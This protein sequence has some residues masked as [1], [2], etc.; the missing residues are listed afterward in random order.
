M[1]QWEVNF[2]TSELAK[3]R[4]SHDSL[5]S[6]SN[7]SKQE[8]EAKISPLR[9]ELE[10]MDKPYHQAKQDYQASKSQA[11]KTHT[12]N[13][14]KVESRVQSFIDQGFPEN[15]PHISQARREMVDLSNNHQNHL[16]NLD[17]TFK[18]LETSHLQRTAPLRSR[19][20][21]IQTQHESQISE[22]DKRL[23]NVSGVMNDYRNRLQQVGI[24]ASNWESRYRTAKNIY[25]YESPNP[26]G[27]ENNYA[28][29]ARAKDPRPLP[30]EC[31]RCGISMK[32]G[33]FRQSDKI[34]GKVCIDCRD[35]LKDRGYTS[36][37]EK[38]E[39]NG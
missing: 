6:Q 1:Q 10:A 19:V 11:Q 28:V 13:I 25:Y 2:Y 34:W 16:K 30:L 15:H 36:Q 18:K 7:L 14:T 20:E 26:S 24:T 5:K 27:S 22:F 9:S 37:D 21:Q 29:N 4:H 33:T 8:H 17:E 23:H 12:S 32:N 3:L 35:E 39:A 31:Q 38:E